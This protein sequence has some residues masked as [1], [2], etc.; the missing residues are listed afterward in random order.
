MLGIPDQYSQSNEQLNVLM[1]QA[2]PKTAASSRAA[3]DKTTIERM[4]LAALSSS[5]A[6]TRNSRQPCR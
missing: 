1:H 2:A 3:L 6:R 4:T 5:A